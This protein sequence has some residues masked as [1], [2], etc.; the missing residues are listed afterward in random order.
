MDINYKTK[1][2]D[3]EYSKFLTYTLRTM[4]DLEIDSLKDEN[5]R[6]WI[7]KNFNSAF[8]NLNTYEF[9]KYVHN[10]VSSNI[11]YREDL[12]DEMIISP[13]IIISHNFLFGDCDDISLLIKTIL[14]FFNIK[15]KYILFSNSWG[16]FTHIALIVDLNN[17]LIYLDGVRNDFNILPLNKYS[18]YKV[19]S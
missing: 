10:Y 2:E 13:R 12:Y 17:K 5:F 4:N 6:E 16:N 7:Y 3:I 19:I 9:L 14:S 8:M 15:A 1:L 11:V 18:F